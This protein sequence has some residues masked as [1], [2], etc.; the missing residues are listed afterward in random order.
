[1]FPVLLSDNQP[2]Y[3][4]YILNS[5]TCSFLILDELLILFWVERQENEQLWR[6]N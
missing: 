4:I 6:K 3:D 1:M 2:V 5:Q